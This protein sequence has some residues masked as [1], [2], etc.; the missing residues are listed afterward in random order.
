MKEENTTAHSHTGDKPIGVNNSEHSQ[1]IV[2][3]NLANAWL[4]YDKLGFKMVPL[5]LK[6]VNGR[7]VVT[8]MPRWKK[9][10]LTSASIKQCHN[11]LAII[12]G[13]ASQLTVIDFDISGTTLSAAL[14][15]YGLEID[16]Y[17]YALTPSGGLHI[18]LNDS[19]DEYLKK[20]YQRNALTT[21]NSNIGIDI[22]A[23]GGLIFAPPS[24]VEGGGNYQWT[25]LP[26]N[27]RD[28]DY[29][30]NKLIPLMDA[31]YGYNHNPSPLAP[32]QNRPIIQNINYLAP[33]EYENNT[34]TITHNYSQTEGCGY[35]QSDYQNV[36]SLI[37]R[38]N[39]RA[40]KIEY[41]DW[42]KMGFAIKNTFG[43]DGWNLWQMFAYNPAYNDN[44]PYLKTKWNSFHN[45]IAK[46][47]SFYYL[48]QIYLGIQI[49]FIQENNSNT[50]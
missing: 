45:P 1:A 8:N 10:A 35:T 40:L 31:I 37:E 43:E 47:N 30:I 2:S 24:I 29:D 42:I 19:N 20:R 22:R 44:I 34:N 18:Y 6:L 11:A 32:A 48:A 17:C 26:V 9:Q 38:F 49:S 27:R 21:T 15:E 39:E 23:E 5:T 36:K 4:Y 41:P 28:L 3:V 33:I 14:N 13:E 7:K 12:T 50:A 46:L 25:N 16:N